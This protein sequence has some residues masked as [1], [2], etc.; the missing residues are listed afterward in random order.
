MS[1]EGPTNM[2]GCACRFLPM[3]HHRSL[4]LTSA[5]ACAGARA[6]AASLLAGTGLAALLLAAAPARASSP[7]AWAALGRE[8][9]S[10]C[11][12][13]SSLRQPRPLGERVDF[14]EVSLLAIGGTYP[15]VHMGNRP[16]M[17]LCLFDRRTRKASVVPGERLIQERTPPA[18][19]PR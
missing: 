3:T 17:E 6:A 18:P 19:Q 16:G 9:T 1:L 10:T 5:R 8:V 2:G 14:E 11:L 4:A 12:A 15:Q 7:Q 13:R